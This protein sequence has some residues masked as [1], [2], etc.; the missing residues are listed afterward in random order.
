MSCKW[1]HNPES[2]SAGG[3]EYEITA[4]DL[5]KEIAKDSLFFEQSGGG[6]TFSGG[7]PFSQAAFLLEILALCE[8]ERIKAAIDTCGYCETETLLKAAEKTNLFLYDIKF[9]DSDKH[10]KYCGVKNDLILSN[11]KA[12]SETKTKLLIRVPVIPSINDDIPE[13]AGIF[14]F[15]KDFKNIETVHLLPYHN[16]QIDKYKRLGIQY[17]LSDISGD[18]S[19]NMKAISR[20]FEGR[21]RAKVGG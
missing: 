7:E 20:I 13:M 1:C 11:L 10:E 12:L 3:T 19:R 2:R 8:K 6:V 17:E 14:E 16:I 5:I 18:E 9:I 15:I 4:A 21:F